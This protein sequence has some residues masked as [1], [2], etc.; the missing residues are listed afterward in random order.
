MYFDRSQ[1]F[2]VNSFLAVF[3]LNEFD[4]I[5]KFSRPHS[6]FWL[7]LEIS[8]HNLQFCVYSTTRKQ[9]TGEDKAALA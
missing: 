5:V 4:N 1:G 2:S 9:L 8:K 7:F 3:N 6:D